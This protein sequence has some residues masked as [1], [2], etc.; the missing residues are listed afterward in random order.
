MTNMTKNVWKIGCNL[1][2]VEMLI[3]TLLFKLNIIFILLL[4]IS[5][6][7]IYFFIY[8]RHSFIDVEQTA[9]HPTEKWEKG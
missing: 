1:N 6:Y 9:K 7:F 3:I 4:Y 2:G 5:N 8:F